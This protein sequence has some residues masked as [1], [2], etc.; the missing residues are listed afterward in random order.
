[1]VANPWKLIVFTIWFMFLAMTAAWENLGPG[2]SI[3]TIIQPL[4][5]SQFHNLLLAIAAPSGRQDT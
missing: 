2:L 1:M 3:L 4:S 5:R